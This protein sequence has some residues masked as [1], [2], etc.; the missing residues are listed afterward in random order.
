MN[1]LFLAHKCQTVETQ[2]KKDKRSDCQNGQ[3]VSRIEIR[4]IS[5]H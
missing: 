2:D 5:P 3:I 1:G 4:Q